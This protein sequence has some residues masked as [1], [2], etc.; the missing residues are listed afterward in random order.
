[1]PIDREPSAPVYV[2][3]STTQRTQ[4]VQLPGSSMARRTSSASRALVI[5][6]VAAVLAIT[7]VAIYLF[8]SA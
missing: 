7:G 1:M 2:G 8:T 5:A 3:S 6:V 4:P